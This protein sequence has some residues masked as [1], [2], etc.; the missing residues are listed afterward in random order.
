MDL[1]RI[2]YAICVKFNFECALL[3]VPGIHNGLADAL[4]R[5]RIQTFLSNHPT[6]ELTS[7]PTDRG[8]DLIHRLDISMNNPHSDL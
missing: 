7:S 2:L 5:G 1:I 4:S 8:H 3:H 6:A